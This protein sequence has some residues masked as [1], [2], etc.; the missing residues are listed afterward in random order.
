[1]Q[2]LMVLEK[3][4]V[5][6]HQSDHHDKEKHNILKDNRQN[7]NILRNRFRQLENNW[8][9]QKVWLRER[10]RQ[11]KNHWDFNAT[12]ITVCG[13][14]SKSTHPVRSKDGDLLSFLEYIKNVGRAFQWYIE[15]TIKW[16]FS[17]FNDLFMVLTAHL[18]KR[19]KT[20]WITENVSVDLMNLNIT[21]LFRKQC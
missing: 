8:F 5:W 20:F 4:K 19:F 9:Q 15:K 1:M 12:L 6:N 16:W 18:L 13:P 14:R 2:H 3:V 17:I 11:E 21:T 7:R 10:F